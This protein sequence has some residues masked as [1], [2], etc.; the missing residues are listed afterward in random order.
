MTEAEW[1]SCDDTQKMLVF[2]RTSC[3]RTDRKSR[4]FGA[5]C[6]QWLRNSVEAPAGRGA[7]GV[8]KAAAGRISEDEIR[9]VLFPC[10]LGMAAQVAFLRDVYGPLPFRSVI[11]APSW[12]TSAVVAMATAIYNDR[13]FVVMPVLA[14]AL[15]EAGCGDPEILGH[16]R[17]GQGHVRG[18]WALDLGLGKE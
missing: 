15:E 9:R 18:C 1:N 12:R 17:Q 4:L 8:A 11:V 16:L 13:D 6:V 5:N 2:L 10:A 3:V 7:V 14:D